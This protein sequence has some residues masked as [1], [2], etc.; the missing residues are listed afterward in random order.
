MYARST[1]VIVMNQVNAAKNSAE[2]RTAQIM[3]TRSL[4]QIARR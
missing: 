1:G 2:R 4:N 3:L